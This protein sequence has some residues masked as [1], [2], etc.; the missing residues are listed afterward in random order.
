MLQSSERKTSQTHLNLD[1]MDF[2][3][4][5]QKKL[6]EGWQIYS[7]YEA[8]ASASRRGEKAGE[9]ANRWKIP[10]VH[11]TPRQLIEDPSV[12]IVDIA[13]PPD[14]QPE[15]IRHALKQKHVRG[16]LAQKPLAMDFWLAK[17][18]VEEATATGKVL[19]VNQNMRFDRSINRCAFSSNCSSRMS[20]GRR[21]WERS[22]C[23]QYRIG[24]PFWPRITGLRCST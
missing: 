14:Q 22:R 15:L 18:L 16:I 23:V 17:L 2:L 12:E 6:Q 3:N 4:W 19:S 10:T 13:F 21:F 24:N 20:W 9:V 5:V 11:Q 7:C 8:G 1:D